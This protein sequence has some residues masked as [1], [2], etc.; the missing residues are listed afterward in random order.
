MRD[1]RYKEQY[2][3][4]Q[5]LGTKSDLCR[6]VSKRGDPG[7]L[8]MACALAGTDG[9]SST[10]YRTKS[11]AEGFRFS[12][13]DY[14][15]DI[16]T[17]GRPD[18]CRILKVK[19]APKDKWE[20]WC[21]V[22]GLD[23][24]SKQEKM[25][26]KPP[27]EIQ[28]MLWFYDGIMIWYR[29]KD[30][31]LDYSENTFILSQGNLAINEDP[32]R[33]K[34][35][36]ITL[37]PSYGVEPPPQADQFIRIGENSNMDMEDKVTIKDLRAFSTWVKFENF[38]NNARIF[39]FG[40]G[41]GNDNVF[42]GIEGKG[43]DSSPLNEIG[44][45]PDNIVCSKRAPIEIQPQ[46]YMK[47]TEANVEDYDC[48]GPEPIEHETSDFVKAKEKRKVKLANLIF[49]IWDKSQRKMRIKII[50]AIK[51]NTWHHIALTTTDLSF[52]PGWNVYIDGK[53]VFTK[54][55]GF[56]PQS[57][58]VTL[59]YI[60]RSNWEVA[61]NQGEY[62]D[63]RFRGSLFDFRMYRIPMP[64]TKLLKTVEW[65]KKLLKL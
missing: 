32:T 46:L 5:K 34:T 3:D 10:L 62:K 51:E 60:G 28:D 54:L 22:A 33:E 25:D 15:T 56:L 17:D 26:A 29:F 31:M 30:D 40:N 4:I 20:S 7:T 53:K 12:R 48:P 35:D 57:N 1:L 2:V 42:L 11:K 36:G 45:E 39:D 50:D 16:N 43:N 23:S 14:F 37:N 6:V 49:E 9:S 21:A 47:K 44:K 27:T 59:N 13:D 55:D 8:I 64:E 24:F 52:T 38:T 19:E 61:L 65:G 63:E 41:A 58:Y 18:Y